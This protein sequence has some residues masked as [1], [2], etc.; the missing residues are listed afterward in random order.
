MNTMSWSNYNILFNTRVLIFFP[1]YISKHTLKK[2]LWIQ[3]WT[4]LLSTN[5]RFIS[6]HAFQMTKTKAFLSPSSSKTLLNSKMIFSVPPRD[7]H[8]LTWDGSLIVHLI[9]SCIIIG[10]NTLWSAT[11][12]TL[13]AKDCSFK[14]N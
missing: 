1:S 7:Q 11:L 4:K 14:K 2:I 10:T 13:F 8:C 5:A 6:R 3:P 12:S 9:T